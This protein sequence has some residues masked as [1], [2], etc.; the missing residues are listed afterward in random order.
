MMIKYI[1]IGYGWRAD[2]YMQAARKMP[3][4][5]C[6]TA[7]VVRTES[8][9]KELSCKGENATT[10]LNEAL[11]SECDFAVLCVPRSEV[12][13]YLNILAK[14]QIPILCETPPGENVNDLNALWKLANENSMK[15]QV[16]EQYI[17]WPFYSAIKN[18]INRGIIGETQSIMI[19][20]VHDYHAMNLVRKFLDIGFETCKI[21][22][23]SFP[24]SL[25]K[26]ESREGFDY[27][28]EIISAQRDIALIEFSNGKT[29]I[30]DFNGV[31]YNS[32]IRTRRINIQGIRG[33]INDFTVRFLNDR[34]EGI[35]SE[36]RRKDIGV[37]GNSG[38]SHYG[39][40]FGEDFVY[41]SPYPGI[42]INDDEIAVA[43]CLEKMK[44]Y[45]DSGTEFSSLRDALQDTYLS[46]VMQECMKRRKSVTTTSQLWG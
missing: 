10:D 44:I 36:I 25:V 24:T 20:A 8:R 34:N 16:A 46:F 1:V 42:R 43:V 27:S 45:V 6:V 40:Q 31:Q 32:V 26:T 13:K 2:F 15:I 12:K 3:D 38:W 17:F 29:A 9:A 21:Q 33:E 7:R 30:Y 19:S 35:E 4:R 23:A 11:K 39:M 28:G 37:M 5:F 22:G 18:I 41:K 14:K